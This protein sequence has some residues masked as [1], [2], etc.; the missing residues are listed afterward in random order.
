MVFVDEFTFFQVSFFQN[1]EILE[2]IIIFFNSFL[3]V[4][5]GVGVVFLNNCVIRI[6][7]KKVKDILE[8]SIDNS[9]FIY[10]GNLGLFIFGINTKF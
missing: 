2:K 3:L 4:F 5:C 7:L 8:L 9:S 6:I 10:L 1:K